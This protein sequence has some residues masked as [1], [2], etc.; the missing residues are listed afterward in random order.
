MPIFGFFCTCVCYTFSK[1]AAHVYHH[2]HYLIY[3]SMA[4]RSSSVSQN[5]FV[6]VVVVCGC[7]TA[8]YFSSTRYILTLNQCLDRC[9][10]V[11]AFLLSTANVML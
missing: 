5:V 7:R 11:V 6:L 1:P 10:T 4:E 2:T 3:I 8:L 9:F